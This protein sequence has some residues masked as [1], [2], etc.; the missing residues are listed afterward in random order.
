MAVNERIRELRKH[1]KLTQRKFG[2][3]IGIAQGHLT[4]LESGSKRVTDKTLKTICSIYGVSEKWM[5]GG[6]GDM[7]FKASA[8]KVER[9]TSLFCKLAPDFQNF[10]Q[11]QIEFLLELQYKQTSGKNIESKS[12]T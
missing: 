7:F 6:V 9:F 8:E 11:Q 10:V 12:N 4:G 5:R 3:N 1:L 2:Y